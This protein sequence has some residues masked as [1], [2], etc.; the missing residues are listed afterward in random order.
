MGDSSKS[1]TIEQESQGTTLSRPSIEPGQLFI[2]GKWREGSDGKRR[3]VI[4]P[5]T[6]E[7][8]T[9]VAEASESDLNDAVAAARKAFDEGP[10]PRLSGRE[11]GGVL[12]RIAQY[13]REHV[14]DL[15]K[16]ESIDAGHPVVLS[17]PIDVG[18]VIDI[19]DYYAGLAQTIEG[20]TRD[21]PAPTMVYTRREPIGVVGAITPF[22]FPLILSSTKIAP[23]LA[24][25]NTV[26]QKPASETPLSA[27]WMAK[28]LTHAGVPEG[29]FNVITGPGSSIG[30]A[31]VHHPSVDKI[32]FTG[33]TDVGR[34]IARIAGEDLKPVTLEL[35]GKSAHIIFDDADLESAIPAVI[36][37]F[38][39]NAGQFCMAGT[40][41]LVARPLLDTV[42]QALVEGASAI[43]LGDPFD[44]S[45]LVGPMIS[46]KQ[47]Q[48]T[49]RYV[50]IAE[51]QEKARIICG[52]QRINNGGGFFYSPTVVTEVN[53]QSR[54]VQ[55]EIFGPVIT[56]QSFD[57]EEEAIK[58]ANSTVFGLAA[59]LHTRDVSR[60]H[61]VAAQL[62][63]GMVWVNTYGILD[64]AIPYGGY[65]QSGYGREYGPEV[66]NYYTQTKSVMIA[67]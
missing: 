29:V 66:L 42:S 20:A 45:T 11:R 8:I 58:L 60:A 51:K 65:K 10:W 5:S 62:R 22:N 50:D 30:E 32:A 38:T 39:L 16:I 63:A 6:G 7:V 13:I 59:G 33:S 56:V 40:R 35:G 54:L 52:G 57:T 55:E 67:L 21:I 43:P 34:R 18:T 48:T 64:P 37:G 41:L 15:S 31:I 1:V 3:E 26:V 24:V 25:G 27:L 2:D 61:R 23:A 47:I 49:E 36:Q 28:A 9:T 12:H 46:E 44:P 53:N 4:D 19:F 14:D 17:R